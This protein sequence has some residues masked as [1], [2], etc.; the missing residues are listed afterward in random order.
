MSYFSKKILVLIVAGLLCSQ[1]NAYTPTSKE[2]KLL[3]LASVAD[4]KSDIKRMRKLL[5][6]GT[7]IEVRAAHGDTPLL[8][9]IENGKLSVVELLLNHGAKVNYTN[10]AHDQSPLQRAVAKAI[11]HSDDESKRIDF[12]KI[13]VLLLN[14]NADPDLA[15]NHGRSARSLAQKQNIRKELKDLLE[16]K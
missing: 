1:V 2:E 6:K 8:H 12:T 7:N 15:D 4:G 11:E 5:N 13:V 10:G 9:A 3:L 16:V 14:K